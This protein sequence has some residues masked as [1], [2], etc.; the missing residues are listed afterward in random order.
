MNN[1]LISD[2]EELNRLEAWIEKNE[3]LIPVLKIQ[4]R[5]DEASKINQQ[6]ND[7]RKYAANFMAALNRHFYKQ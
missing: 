5:S 4:G 1:L 6:L 2:H 7:A 3:C